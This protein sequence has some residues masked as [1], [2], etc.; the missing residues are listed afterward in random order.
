MDSVAVAVSVACERVDLASRGVSHENLHTVG[1]RI[2]AA[3]ALEASDDVGD[4]TGRGRDP[5][6][7]CFASVGSRIEHEQIVSDGIEGNEA[8]SVDRPRK[9]KGFQGA[10]GSNSIDYAGCRFTRVNNIRIHIVECD[11]CGGDERAVVGVDDLLTFRTSGDQCQIS[12]RPLY[13]GS[14]TSASPA[15]TP[16]SA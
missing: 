11:I 16:L 14:T 5:Y 13:P 7:S 2:N 12:S 4:N 6:E 3:R 8:R 9:R 10:P 1:R 15:E